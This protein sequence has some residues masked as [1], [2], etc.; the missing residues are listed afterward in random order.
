MRCFVCTKEH[1]NLIK[2][3][4]C[5]NHVCKNCFMVMKNYTNNF[6]VCQYVDCFSYYCKKHLD[7]NSQCNE[8]T[9]NKE[10]KMIICNRHNEKVVN[11][12]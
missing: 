1:E 10:Y 4:K 9:Y 7:K 3:G 2:C 5:K 8:L 12:N 6:M 11:E